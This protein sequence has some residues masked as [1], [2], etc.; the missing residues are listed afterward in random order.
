MS[1][2]KPAARRA[3]PQ[4]LRESFH[5]LIRRFG[6]LDS[7]RTPCGQPVA[8]SHAHALMELLNKPGTRQGE[9]A[10]LLGLSKSAVSR[11]VDQL[12]RRGWIERRLDD[13]D[14]RVRHLTLTAKGLRLAQKID[15]TSIAR[16]S[17][18]LDGVPIAARAQVI[19]SLE[20]LH[21]A[22]PMQPQDKPGH[23][24]TR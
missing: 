19:A 21:K 8:V 2:G 13:E 10:R 22:I 14:G 9:L 11:M 1:S 18:M 6:L 7:D 24:K 20:I 17:A 23:V 12:E 4:T 16:F 3:S 5:A 15:L